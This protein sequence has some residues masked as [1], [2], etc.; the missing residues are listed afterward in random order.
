MNVIKK[1]RAELGYTQ[2]ALAEKTGLSLRTIQ[3]IEGNAKVP[4]GHT[5]KSLSK[6]FNTEPQAL[7]KRFQTKE[8]TEESDILSI[9]TI[10]I[11]ILAFF[12]T[13]L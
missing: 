1:K 3:R 11:S 4:K 5:L 12:I 13:P 9:K 10:N 8:Q 6:A 2:N 7:Q